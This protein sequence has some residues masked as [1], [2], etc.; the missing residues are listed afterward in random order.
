LPAC[1]A[2]PAIAPTPPG[3]G[4]STGDGLFTFRANYGITCMHRRIEPQRTPLYDCQEPK[5]STI[6]R[7]PWAE[8]N[9]LQARYHDDEWGVPVHDDRTFF[10]FLILEGAQAGLSWNTVLQRRGQY[11]KAFA[12]FNPARVACFGHAEITRLLGN[13]GIIRN[14]L[15]IESAIGNARAFLAV[16]QQFGS[17][18]AYIWRFVNGKPQRKMRRSPADVPA[19]TPESDAMSRDLKAR[20]FRFVGSTICYAYMQAT[21]LV[22]DH[23]Q[24]C[25]RRARTGTLPDR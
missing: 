10:E 1:R 9:P 23:L 15:K 20:G 22:D 16:Q 24:N 18:D 25:W 4:G 14:R 8:A 13:P 19:Q 3:A 21:G 7:C 5:M 11:R 2:A 6:R 17:F 12:A